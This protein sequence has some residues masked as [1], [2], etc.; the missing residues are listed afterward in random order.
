MNARSS[1]SQSRP[2]RLT[3]PETWLEAF[4]EQALQMG[5]VRFGIAPAVEMVG[6]QKLV[7]W[8]E[9]GHAAE[10]AY[11]ADRL[12]AYRHPRG[13][14]EGVK[15]I[16]VLMYPYPADASA[17]VREGH[18]R[19]AR[20]AWSG[21]DYHDVIHAKLKRL[22]RW[23][24]QQSPGVSVR[25]CVDT[26]P[27][28]ER[29]LAE[30]A[31]LGWRGKNTLL[32]NRQDGSYFFLASLLLN[33]ELPPSTPHS[34][35][36][37]GTCTACL[38]AC[39]TQAFP[40]PGVLDASQCISYWTIEH[41]DAIPEEMREPIGEWAFGCD[42]CQEVCPWNRKVTRRNETPPDERRFEQLELV[43]LF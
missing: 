19:V 37:C 36:H 20:Y 21:V 5:F 32:L 29:E 38:D 2:S 3:D 43:K 40:S 11:F 14:M 22:R 35:F 28:M 16:V 39:P 7:E 17:A 24:E 1:S 13:V 25:G 42:I 34:H 27:L 12:D 33:I 31:G 30:I 23:I 26:A 18:G 6:F 8:I 15:S 41:R 4:G 10:M 9:S